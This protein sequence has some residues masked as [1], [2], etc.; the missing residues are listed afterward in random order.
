MVLT[1]E[2]GRTGTWKRVDRDFNEVAFDASAHGT[3]AG[4]KTVK[5]GSDVLVEIPTTW[6]KSEVLQSG[7]YKGKTCWWT[8]D[9]IR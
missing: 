9:G 4:M 8:A 5:D 2:G 1:Q 3:W 6:V 7:P